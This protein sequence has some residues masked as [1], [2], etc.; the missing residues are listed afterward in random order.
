MQ[1]LDERMLE[2]L[3]EESWLSPPLMRR[4]SQFSDLNASESRIRE[5]CPE[6]INRAVIEP[7]TSQS[8]M[9]EIT[10]WR[11]AY[12]RGQLDANMRRRWAQARSSTI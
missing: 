9:Y 1:Q 6:L 3:D 8:D 12:R 7:V 2:H 4:E 10:T 11:L 5:R